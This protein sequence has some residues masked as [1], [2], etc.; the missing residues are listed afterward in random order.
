MP[1]SARGLRISLW[2]LA[3]ALAAVLAAILVQNGGAFSYTLDDPYIHLA[4]AENLLKG[5]YG[6]NLGEVSAPSS[7]ILWPFLMAPFQRM[8]ALGLFG[9]LLVNLACA[10]ATL[11]VLRSALARVFDYRL[12][13]GGTALI[14][15]LA[16]AF[17]NLV[18][19]VYMGMEHSL[20][21]L[22]SAA[23]A[24]GLLVEIRDGR[25]PGWLPVVL[26][27]GPLVRYENIL[28]SGCAILYLVA[29]KRFAAGA[30]TA[31]GLLLLMGG[32]SLWLKHLGLYPL[33]TSVVAKTLAGQSLNASAGGM[34]SDLRL[35]ISSDQGS[36]MVLC[37]LLLAGRIFFPAS[38]RNREAGPDRLLAASATLALAT[39][40]F[41]SLGKA[42]SFNRY[43][44]YI[45]IYCLVILSWLYRDLLTGWMEA[46]GRAP[47]ARAMAAGLALLVTLV[48]CDRNLLATVKLPAD[49]NDIWRQQYQMGRFVRDVYRKP[50]AVNDLGLVSYRNDGYVLDLWGLASVEALRHR[51]HQTSPE[52]MDTLAHAHGVGLVMIYDDWFPDGVPASWI[53]VGALQRPARSHGG[54]REVAFYAV[55]EA[56]RAEVMEKLRAFRPTLPVNGPFVFADEAP[57]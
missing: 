15:T 2:I 11:L 51:L 18:A 56:A 29:R 57:R 8:P 12:S 19:L 54:G 7:S 38:A 46:A 40:L 24:L 49:A 27:L 39:H 10:F 42:S 44:T 34:F 6:V 31:A 45:W 28:L 3:A 32:F 30:F 5:H 1:A 53:R 23:A 13:A 14:L 33:P 50:V 17:A 9:P 21:V 37:L 35:V 25:V 41:G 43:D 20:Q 4:M 22:L 16:I 55:D 26:I 48:V 52:W 47:R 36:Y